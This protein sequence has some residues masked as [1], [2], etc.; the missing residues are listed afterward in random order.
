[1]HRPPSHLHRLAGFT[2]VEL[3][4]VIVVMAIIAATAIPSF[5]VAAE[6]RG[7]AATRE[8]ERRLVHARARAG[9]TGEPTGLRIDSSSSVT[10]VRIA[11]SGASPTAAPSPTGEAGAAW[12]ISSSFPGVLISKVI[13]GDGSSATS[14]TIWFGF[15]GA[16]ELR[17][18]SGTL[19]GP[20]T[21]DA[22]ITLSGPGAGTIRILRGSGVVER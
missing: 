15:D 18:S 16:P 14:Q 7:V 4:V 1:L 19:V 13:G 9:A 22:S 17:S 10:L 2:L 5:S 6:A 20:F 11:A 3:A 8:V 12:L 21:Q